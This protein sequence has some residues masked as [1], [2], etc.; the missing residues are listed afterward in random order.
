MKPLYIMIIMILSLTLFLNINNVSAATND[1]NFTIDQVSNAAG[2]VKSYVETNHQLPTSVN[3]S[4][5]QVSMPQFLDLSSSAIQ[6]LNNNSNSNVVLG[7]FGAA[8]SPSENLTSNNLNSLNSTEYVDISTRV[9]NFMHSNGLAPNY[10]SSSIGKIRYESL[11]YMNSLILNSYYKTNQMPSFIIINPWSVVSNSNTLFYSLDQIINASSRVQSWAEA[12]HQL[13]AYVTISGRQVN[14]ASLLRVTTTAVLDIAG[15][16]DTNHVIGSYSAASNPSETINSASMGQVEYLKVA[17]SVTTYL[18]VFGQAPNYAS[19]TFGNMRFESLVYMYSQLL[20]Y[21]NKTGYLPAN[22]TVH[23]WSIISNSNTAFFAYDQINNASATV[24]SY[25]ETNHALPGSVTISGKQVSMPQFLKLST[26]TL[27]YIQGTLCTSFVYT[28]YGSAPNPSENVTTSNINFTEYMEI[29]SRVNSFMNS[30]KMAPNYATQTST[31]SLIRYESLVYMYSQIL[32]SYNTNN[33]I[34]PDYITVYPWINVS[35]SN[36]TFFSYDQINNASATVKSYVET[37]HLLPGSV[38]ITGK[39]VNMPQFFKLTIRELLNIESNL[40]TSILLE[41]LDKFY[42]SAEDITSGDMDYDEYMSIAKYSKKFIEV[43]G[44]VPDFAYQTSLGPHMGF[45]SLVYMYSQ[46]L[47]NYNTNNKTLP[48]YLTVTP[49]LAVS[50]PN[51]IYNYQSNKVFNS[52]QAAID[53]NDT[54]YGDTIG[55]GKE[56]ISENIIINKELTIIPITGLNVTVRAANANLPVFTITTNGSGSFISDLIISGS[57]NGSGIYFNNSYYNTIWNNLISGNNNGIC[58]YN[59]TDNEV[60]GNVV[61]NNTANGIFIN[62]G[63]D[64]NK[65]TDNLVMNNG[66]SGINISRSQNNTISCNIITNNSIDGIRSY[67]SSAVI[68]FNRIAA[69]NRYGLYNEGNGVV[70][71]TNNWWGSNNPVVS[72]NI[73]SDICLNGGNVTYNPWL[74][75]NV[76]S[77]CD[78]SELNGTTYKYIITADMTH[79]NQGKDTSNDNAPSTGNNLPDGIPINFNTTFGTINTPVYTRNGKA[80]VILNASSEGLANLSI[81]LDN[82]NLTKSVNIT[83][84]NI[85]GIHNNRTCE[86]FATIQSAIDSN[87]TLNGDTIT[88]ADGTYTENVVVYKKLTIMPLP[89]ANVTVLAANYNNGVFTLSENGTTLKNL[90]IIGATNSY[91]IFIYYASNLNIINNTISANNY[92]IE[93]YNSNNNTISGNNITANW[94]GSIIFNSNNITLSKNNI[95]NNWYGIYP[96]HVQNM[97]ISGNNVI[98]NWYGIYINISNGTRISGNNITNNYVGISL[99]TSNNTNISGNFLK[100]NWGGISFYKSNNTVISGN[101]VIGSLIADISEIDFTGVVLQTNI[102]SCGPASLATVLNKIGVNATEQEIADLAGTDKSGTTM[103]GLVQAA[104]SKGLNAT[105]MMLSVDQL[106]PHNIVLLAENGLYHFSVIKE[107]TNT[108]VFLADSAFGNIQLSIGN[109]TAKYSGYAL[110]VTNNSTNITQNGTVLT[111]DQMLKI[112]GTSVNV[113]EYAKWGLALPGAGTIIYYAARYAV[114]VLVIGVLFAQ[115]VGYDESSYWNNLNR[116][117]NTPRSSSR[118]S[119]KYKSRYSYSTYS[120][121]PTKRYTPAPA[122]DPAVLEYQRKYNDF[123]NKA[124]ANW[125]R[126]GEIIQTVYKYDKN[127]NIKELTIEYQWQGG[128]GSKDPRNMTLKKVVLAGFV[129]SF[130]VEGYSIASNKY[131][132]NYTISHVSQAYDAI[133]QSIWVNQNQNYTC[134]EKYIL[135]ALINRNQIDGTRTDFDNVNWAKIE[136]SSAMKWVFQRQVY[137]MQAY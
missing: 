127:G 106:K 85:L 105:G 31:C 40:Y 102:F 72:S 100:D 14:M 128:S 130:I 69:N 111:N 73:S 132:R 117:Y 96:Y 43:N 55:L 49:W 41:D 134:D 124:T 135:L 71:A 39:K 76:T 81:N 60:T 47:N 33:K 21:Y 99:S 20:S 17:S 66:N 119:S 97:E 34:L 19:T 108:T 32:N 95:T 93:L 52:I 58:F 56:I 12:N 37:N 3:I 121:S 35:N 18:A 86:G 65:F 61:I 115:P 13:P 107:I 50:N 94:Y 24:K 78:R 120:R 89:G 79:N 22:I 110:V 114:P 137:Q 77:S 82:Q 136:N 46:I 28:T 90:N 57:T 11:I 88:L 112:S 9:K 104:R 51:A 26:E 27:L 113:F 29:A 87:N 91:G 70:D 23:P 68:K 16:F 64:Y 10:A 5:S 74:V 67:N 126:I 122:V 54:F 131:L 42:M 7:S 38:N 98:D 133:S 83:S 80:I 123:K 59:S 92:G 101:N 118:S 44:T 25:V 116:N 63:S 45:T 129:I 125:N 8:P 1:T 30:N 36:A 109:F 15:N 53:D 103:Y 4:G 48:A 62:M 2:T 75:L 6:N 84:V